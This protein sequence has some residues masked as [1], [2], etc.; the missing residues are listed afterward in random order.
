MGQSSKITQYQ[1]EAR[2]LALRVS[3]ASHEEIAATVTRELRSEKKIEDTIS[4]SSVTRWLD[5][6]DADRRQALGAIQDE[7]VREHAVSDL[8]KLNELIDYHY[9][10][11]KG[12]LEDLFYFG[13]ALGS[14]EMPITLAI[15]TSA[16]RQ[17]HELLKTSFRFMGVAGG[18]LGD[19]AD[20]P[21]DLDRYKS[22]QP[23][24]A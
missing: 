9:R 6:T 24:Q 18:P 2:V 21:V 7:Y 4:R 5:K 8:E 19:E 3:G 22:K 12:D 17:L 16:G 15:Q 14:K 1:L 10:L 20:D 11:W 13:K 23:D